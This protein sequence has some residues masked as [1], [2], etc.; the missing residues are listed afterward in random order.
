MDWVDLSSS[1][2]PDTLLALQQH[3]QGVEGAVLKADRLSESADADF[4]QPPHLSQASFQNLT[5]EFESK[6]IRIAKNS[7]FKEQSYWDERFASEEKFEWLVTFEQVKHHVL[8]IIPSKDCTILIVGCGNSN[9]SR[10]LYNEGYHQITN[11]DFSPTV[12]EKMTLRHIELPDM[13][14]V[15]MDM[16][17]LAEFADGSFDIVL[18][19]AAMDALMVDEEDVWYPKQEVV[20]I[21][22][23]MCRNVSRVMH[24]TTGIHIQISFA[25]PH[26]RTKYLMASRFLK[27]EISHYE[28]IQGYCEAYNWHLT[29]GTIEIESGCLNTFVY[30]MH[31]QQLHDQ[32]I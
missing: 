18:D 23:K 20:E 31:R 3:L 4:H 27:S 1:L 2:S 12:I 9:F 5:D 15:C 30:Y 32:S 21:T 29:F 17:D 25:Q 13:K 28:S 26:F 10:D 19:K 16:T 8:P 14:W 7:D 24:P 6:D 22:D 11:I